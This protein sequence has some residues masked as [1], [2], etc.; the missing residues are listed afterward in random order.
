MSIVMWPHADRPGNRGSFHTHQLK[1]VF[2]FF[3]GPRPSLSP[4]HSPIRCILGLVSG[5]K[6]LGMW[7]TANSLSNSEVKIHGAIPDGLHGVVLI[8]KMANL[9]LGALT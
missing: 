2:H 5:I 8:N 3:N 4:I 9:V 1:E 7:L 6:W